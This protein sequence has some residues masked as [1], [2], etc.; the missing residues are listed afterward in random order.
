MRTEEEIK[1]QVELLESYLKKVPE[2]NDF[3]DDNYGAIRAQIE[4][5]TERMED[6]EL[7]YEEFGNN[8]YITKSALKAAEWLKDRSED[9][10]SDDWASMVDE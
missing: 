7:I 10:P 5:L 2:F 8:E 6:N 9:K 4:V 3:D 1:G